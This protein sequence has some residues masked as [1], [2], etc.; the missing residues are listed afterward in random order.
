MPPTPAHLSRNLNGLF[1]LQRP[2]PHMACVQVDVGHNVAELGV[3]AHAQVDEIHLWVGRAG[4]VGWGGGQ[5]SGQKPTP[6]PQPPTR[7]TRTWH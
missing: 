5:V 4:G 2:Q 6:H 3:A 7:S 1:R